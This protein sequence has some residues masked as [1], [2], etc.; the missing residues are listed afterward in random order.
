MSL[1]G[2]QVL[3]LGG[4]SGIGLAVA[5]AA[6]AQGAKLTIASSRQD[7]VDKA[8]AQLPEGVTGRA[9]DLTDGDRVRALFGEFGALDHL[10]YTAGEPLLL[11]PLADL[12]VAAARKFFELRYFGAVTAVQAAAPHLTPTGSIT[13]TTGT[14]GPRPVPGSII[15]SSMCGAVEALTR[16][17]AVEL[18]PLRV[19][20]VMPGVVRSPLWNF[21]EEMREQFYDDTAA[22][23]PLQRIAEVADVARAY[24][25]LLTQPHATGTIL[26][27]DGGGVLS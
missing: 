6:A 18:A 11:A 15:T 27:V 23:T 3:V 9:V 25:Y 20:A 16:A 24:L 4:T 13:L 26:T 10:V 17:L 1:A 8:L 12:D 14:A 22:A 2:Q 5:Q 21:P 19:N 7:S